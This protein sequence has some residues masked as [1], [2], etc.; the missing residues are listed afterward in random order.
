M[1]K[2]YN[3]TPAIGICTNLLAVPSIVSQII[4][5]AVLSGGKSNFKDNKKVPTSSFT[6]ILYGDSSVPSPSVASLRSC[7]VTANVF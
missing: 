2:V 5:I 6:I 4:S 1:H 7:T 3:T